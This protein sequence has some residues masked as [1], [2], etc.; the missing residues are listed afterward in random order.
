MRSGV[1]TV[2]CAQSMYS[3]ARQKSQTSITRF[4]SFQRI[5]SENRKSQQHINKSKG[6]LLPFRTQKSDQHIVHAT[7][8]LPSVVFHI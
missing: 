3:V 6:Y 7:V 8:V 1:Q 4:S 5:V 2:C